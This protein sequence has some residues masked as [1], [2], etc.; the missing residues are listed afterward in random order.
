MLQEE[1]FIVMMLNLYVEKLEAS[2]L[3]L[4]LGSKTNCY[5]RVIREGTRVAKMDINK[6]LRT[7]PMRINQDSVNLAPNLPIG[8]G[9]VTTSEVE[10][11]KT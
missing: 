4:I 10:V 11:R 9:E 6:S 3:W 5:G 2:S 8:P 7:Q 1:R